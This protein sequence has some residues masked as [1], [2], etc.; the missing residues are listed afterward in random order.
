[1]DFKVPELVLA[2][3][4]GWLRKNLVDRFGWWTE[5]SKLPRTAPSSSA[6]NE[7]TVVRLKGRKEGWSV[8][9]VT[10]EALQ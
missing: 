8:S 3:R 9:P 2:S 7:K 5:R 10:R 1:M 6:F 4:H